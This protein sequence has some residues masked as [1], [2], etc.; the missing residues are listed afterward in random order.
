MIMGLP[1]GVAVLVFCV[2]GFVLLTGGLIAYDKKGK[3]NAKTPEELEAHNRKMEKI[4]KGIWATT[5]VIGAAGAA[6]ERSNR[7]MDAQRQ[8]AEID[9]YNEQVRQYNEQVMRNHRGY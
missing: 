4:D 8:Q 5:A 7:K 1:G 2:L 9:R 3:K 6:M